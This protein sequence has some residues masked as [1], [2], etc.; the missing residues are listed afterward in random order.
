LRKNLI[1]GKVARGRQLTR[2]T[3]Q[4]EGPPR[5]SNGRPGV[6][7]VANSIMML[8]SK[9]VLY[10]CGVFGR[11]YQSITFCLGPSLAFLGTLALSRKAWDADHVSGGTPRALRHLLIARNLGG[12]AS[13]AGRHY[14][15]ISH[16]DHLVCACACVFTRGREGGVQSTTTCCYLPPSR[17]CG[18]SIVRSFSIHE[19]ECAW[20][21]HNLLS[22][23]S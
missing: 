3:E 16:R 23:T 1:H 2:P 22:S 13:G 7:Q 18:N 8:A 6:N 12:M 19:R 21:S 5:Q 14:W 11:G 17:C 9:I 10:H 4:R 20:S 15:L